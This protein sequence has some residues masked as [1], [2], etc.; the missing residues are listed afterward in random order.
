MQ[1][2]YLDEKEKQVCYYIAGKILQNLSKS[3]FCKK[4]IKLAQIKKCLALHGKF[5]TI[6]SKDL[7]NI[8][9]V[10][11]NIFKFLLK[12]E[13]MFRKLLPVARERNIR[14]MSNEIIKKIEDFQIPLFGESQFC[15]NI[16]KTLTKKFVLF[17]MKNSSLSQ[18]KRKFIY[19][20]SSHSM[21]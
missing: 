18:K 17:R 19:N 6:K 10:S 7:K 13:I 15:H 1:S 9:F 12:M 16:R 21:N 2:I 4:C 20:P 8:F 3:N 11:S 14:Y 5:A